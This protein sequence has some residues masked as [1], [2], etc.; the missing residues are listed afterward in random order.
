MVDAELTRTSIVPLRNNFARETVEASTHIRREPLNG[1]VGS[2]AYDALHAFDAH[3]AVSRYLRGVW[4]MIKWGK[5]CASACEWPVRR[6]L[7]FCSTRVCSI[8]GVNAR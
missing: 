8:D 2:D 6:T 7:N 5:R 4:M 3:V 1:H